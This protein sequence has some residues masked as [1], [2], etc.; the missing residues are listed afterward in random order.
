MTTKVA[1]FIPTFNEKNSIRELVLQIINSKWTSNIELKIYIATAWDSD[2]SN[3]GDFTSDRMQTHKIVN[4]LYLSYPNLITH[5]SN[6]CN[7]KNHALN[8]LYKVALGKDVYI[9]MDADI[10]LKDEFVLD[11]LIRNI[12]VDKYYLAS[13]FVKTFKMKYRFPFNKLA[14]IYN[15]RLYS[16]YKNARY[17]NGRLFAIKGNVLN[18]IARGGVLFPNDK[19]LDDMYIGIHIPYNKIKMDVD[20]E[21]YMIYFNSY[22]DYYYF[23]S[24]K[25]LGSIYLS[26]ICPDLFNMRKND[27][28]RS[29]IKNLP[30]TSNGI[31]YEVNKLLTPSEKLISFIEKHILRKTVEYYSHSK[32]QSFNNN[33][34]YHCQINNRTTT[35]RA[36]IKE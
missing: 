34:I 35:K 10:K 8:K 13:G 20:A 30:N 1:V 23:K 24:A 36:F 18:E 12:T 32:R 5:V 2:L 6:C 22:K 16:R 4:Q 26:Q 25:V 19:V 27:F 29:E 14:S 33:V 9:I 3:D 21:A 28:L 15:K 7:G 17:C 31:D 11:K